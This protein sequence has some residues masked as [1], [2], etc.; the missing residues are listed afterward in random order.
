[1]RHFVCLYQCIPRAK[2]AMPHIEQLAK[3]T[4]DASCKSCPQVRNPYLSTLHVLALV[5]LA[6][7]A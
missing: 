5:A 7:D 2:R 6:A 1:M 3:L 4:A